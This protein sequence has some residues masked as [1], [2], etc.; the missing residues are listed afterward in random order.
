MPAIHGSRELLSMLVL[1]ILIVP[2]VIAIA[3]L[4]VMLVAAEVAD[5][6]TRVS[7]RRCCFHRC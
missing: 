1:T 5:R 7:H 4:L 6:D 3:V 2:V